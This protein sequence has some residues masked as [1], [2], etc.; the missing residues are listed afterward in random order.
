MP[1]IGAGEVACR[2]APLCIFT[3]TQWSERRLS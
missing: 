1:G 3:V 2:A